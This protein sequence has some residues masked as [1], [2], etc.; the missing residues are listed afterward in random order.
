MRTNTLQVP[1]LPA[2]LVAEIRQ[3]IPHVA[4][5]T[6][7]TVAAQVPA[8]APATSDPYRAE[9]E[10]GVRIAFE[11][12]TRLL[13]DQQSD[14]L[15]GITR[16]AR[17]L[18]RTEARRRRGIGSLLTAY[19]IG[20]GVHWQ[21][22]SSLVLRYGLDPAA[23][24]ELAGLIFA[25]NQQL[26]AA[27]VE[28][29]ATETQTRERHREILAQALMTGMASEGQISRAGWTAPTTLT[30]VVVSGVHVSAVLGAYPDALQAPVDELVGMLVP[31][32]IRATLLRTVA[33]TDAV[34]GPTLPWEQVHHSFERAQALAHIVDVRPLDCDEH[35]VELVLFSE[36]RGDLRSQVL[37]PLAGNERLEQTL[38][39]WLLHVGRR[40]AVAEELFVHPQTVR[41]RMGQIRE[42]YGERLNDPR[43]VLKLIVALG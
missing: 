40:D 16:A 26:T 8:Y 35:L 9:L 7:A 4:E 18:G 23:I 15:D 37:A 27:S 21:E 36:A 41:Y 19:Q 31:D 2:E 30:C 22:V 29:Y 32:A 34:I 10:A 24:S 17:A 33:G 43:E 38:R 20:T 14:A 6:V 25:F 13:S 5:I 12:F 11:G 39:S 3:Q 28:G 1:D 42:L